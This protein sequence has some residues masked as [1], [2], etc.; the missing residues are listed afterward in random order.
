[1]T[2]RILSDTNANAGVIFS[3]YFQDGS[4][5]DLTQ[6]PVD[7]GAVSVIRGIQNFE[8]VFDNDTN[9]TKVNLKLSHFT[10]WTLDRLRGNINGVDKEVDVNQ[11]IVVNGPMSVS[12]SWTKQVTNKYL[13][14]SKSTN[15]QALDG[16]FFLFQI[17]A[18]GEIALPAYGRLYISEM[19]GLLNHSG[20]ATS[21]PMCIFASINDITD[22]DTSGVSDLSKGHTFDHSD[23]AWKNSQDTG[24]DF[25]YQGFYRVRERINS[26]TIRYILGTESTNVYMLNSITSSDATTKLEQCSKWDRRKNSGVSTSPLLPFAPRTVPLS[27]EQWY[28][29][30]T[31]LRA[32]DSIAPEVTGTGTTAETNYRNANLEAGVYQSWSTLKTLFTHASTVFSTGEPDMGEEPINYYLKDR[33]AL[34]NAGSYDEITNGN[35]AITETMV[36]YLDDPYHTKSNVY[37]LNVCSDDYTKQIPKGTLGGSIYDYVNNS[38]YIFPGDN[39]RVMTN[40]PDDMDE[41]IDVLEADPSAVFEDVKNYYLR[42]VEFDYDTGEDVETTYY[43]EVSN[44]NVNEYVYPI[45]NGETLNEYKA[46]VAQYRG[47]PVSSVGIKLFTQSTSAGSTNAIYVTKSTGDDTTAEIVYGTQTDSWLSIPQKLGDGN[48]PTGLHLTMLKSNSGCTVKWR[49]YLYSLKIN[50]F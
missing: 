33:T 25:K 42:S 31:V 23:I 3:G 29:Y 13:I 30:I 50:M 12:C 5:L 37:I 40:N 18:A 19:Y 34:I 21:H 27:Y 17:A 49:F 47:V 35:T 11:P 48:R 26:S 43:I 32:A 15:T 36:V 45:Y 7:S 9:P 46:R 14:T 4:I 22:N 44:G 6:I 24:K 10:G 8:A 16:N 39:V 1:V 28:N 2:I 20:T 38:G 41:L